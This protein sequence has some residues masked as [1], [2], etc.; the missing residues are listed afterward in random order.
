MTNRQSVP[1]ARRTMI[2]HAA[3]GVIEREGLNH[4]S[5]RK[6]ANEAGC[7]TGILTHYFRDKRELMRFAFDHAADT[8]EG[9]IDKAAAEATRTSAL[10]SALNASL[11]LDRAR[12]TEYT[13]YMSFL[14]DSLQKD[15][16]AA[17]FRGRYRRWRALIAELVGQAAAE[18]GIDVNTDTSALAELL[19]AFQDGLPPRVA[20]D[21]SLAKTVQDAMVL[22]I[23]RV[24]ALASAPAPF[25]RRTAP[26]APRQPQPP[27]HDLSLAAERRAHLINST[28]HVIDR[29]GL[30]AATLREVARNAGCTTGAILHHFSSRDELL[31]Q[32]LGE[33]CEPVLHRLEQQ[34]DT[35]ISRVA[36]ELLDSTRG[37][38]VN[39]LLSLQLG[40]PDNAR[41]RST[42]DSISDRLWAIIETALNLTPATDVAV[43]AATATILGLGLHQAV[44]PDDEDRAAALTLLPVLAT[45]SPS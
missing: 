29:S 28:R 35:D 16:S 36:A 38:D 3:W 45:H 1:D 20:D 18:Q 11:P 33:T 40:A 25:T 8:V 7:S 44:D 15:G 32:T 42:I 14:V 2:A 34:A 37:L 30:P 6:I 41:I 26:P 24:L 19:L 27:L 13:V 23:D 21:P 39:L 12:G 31:A 10:R 17:Y 43:T 22:M 9:R 4:T 5:L